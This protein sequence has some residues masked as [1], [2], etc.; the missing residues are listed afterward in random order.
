MRDTLK[1]EE[2]TKGYFVS[3]PETSFV[4]YEHKDIE[5]FLTALYMCGMI[6]DKSEFTATKVEIGISLPEDI[7]VIEQQNKQ[8]SE[9]G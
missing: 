7:V 8:M 3:G 6:D 1:E 9:K 5:P 2:M 4:V